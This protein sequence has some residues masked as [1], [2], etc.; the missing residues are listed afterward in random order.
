MNIL[1]ATWSIDKT[2][3]ILK[4]PELINIHKNGGVVNLLTNLIQIVALCHT[5]MLIKIVL[6][7][8]ATVTNDGLT[9]KHILWVLD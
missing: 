5:A 1:S 4:S 7:L 3:K 9:R 2:A 8:V 6:L